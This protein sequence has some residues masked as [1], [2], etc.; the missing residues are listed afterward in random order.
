MTDDLGSLYRLAREQV[1]S[2]VRSL[3]PQQ[4][5]APVPACPG[6]TVHA[7][8]SH[9][10]G[11]ATDVING[12]LSGV[13]APHQTAAQVEGRAGTPTTVVLREWERTGSQMEA[14]L[15]K[16]GGGSAAP[17]IDVAV[18]EQDI[19]GALGLPGNREGPL[20]DL[21]LG[22]S[23]PLLESRI[24]SSGLPGLKV[25]PAPEAPLIAG[26]EEDPVT[27]RASRFELFR[28][29]YG[30]RSRSQLAHRLEGT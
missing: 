19:R 1:E 18:H 9:L 6:W 14:L 24:E 3:T 17:V 7:L 29:I 25:R 26:R 20:I 23:I 10:A 12:R 11:V 8:V 30:R 27:L 28:S 22:R 15:A 16:S 4:L 2:L 13:P 5:E 21:A